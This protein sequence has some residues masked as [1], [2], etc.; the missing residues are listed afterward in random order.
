MLF[1]N[2]DEVCQ[3]SE[4]LISAM[5]EE[6]EQIGSVFVRMSKVLLEVYTAYCKNHN[7]ATLALK[8]VCP[9]HSQHPTYAHIHTQRHTHTYTHA[10]FHT[11]IYKH[12]RTCTHLNPHPPLPLAL[13]PSPQYM[14]DPAIAAKL[15]ECMEMVRGKTTSW[16]LGS[17]LIK[18]V[19]RI[20]RYH[21]LLTQLKKVSA[22]SK[23]TVQRIT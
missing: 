4:E 14:E 13:S 23:T 10:L 15:Q 17:M 5:E 11:L 22:C 9:Q 16:D 12:T 19:Q 3:I 20:M 8:K 6:R 18:P 7:L 1:G 2:I 21:L